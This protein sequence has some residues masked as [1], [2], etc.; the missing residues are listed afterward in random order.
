VASDREDDAWTLEFKIAKQEMTPF[1]EDKWGFNMRRL[2][3]RL[4]DA[5]YWSIP[6]AHAP[7][8][9]GILEFR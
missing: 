1:N 7:Q 2:Q 9:F 4:G 5:G 6:F 3:T 8:Y